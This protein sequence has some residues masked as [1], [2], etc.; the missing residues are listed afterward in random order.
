MQLREYS[1]KDLRGQIVEI[2]QCQQW[3]RRTHA[4]GIRERA[5]VN[6]HIQGLCSGCGAEATVLRLNLI[7]GKSQP[8]TARADR[9]IYVG[10][11]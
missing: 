7:C 8:A 6:R 11:P 1:H 2:E 4:P 5:Q 9:T 10:F 3:I